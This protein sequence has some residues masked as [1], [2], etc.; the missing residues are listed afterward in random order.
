MTKAITNTEIWETMEKAYN[1]KGDAF[2]TAYHKLLRK[3]DGY[4][5]SGRITIT[6]WERVQE[7]DR[8]L[9]GV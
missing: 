9:T 2:H 5:W 4:R 8:R 6:Q 7:Y 1:R 3:Y